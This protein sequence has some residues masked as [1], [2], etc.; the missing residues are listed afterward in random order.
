MSK[1]FKAIDSNFNTDGSVD[2]DAINIIKEKSKSVLY[3][4]PDTPDDTG[5]YYYYKLSCNMN[6]CLSYVP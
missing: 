2:L 1:S 6:H 3:L 5:Y 4:C